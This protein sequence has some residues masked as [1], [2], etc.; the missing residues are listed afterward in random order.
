MG[1]VFVTGGSGVIGTALVNEPGGAR[2]RG[3]CELGLR[4]TD[5]RDTLLSTVEWAR[6]EG[7][8]KSAT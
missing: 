2:R 7:L 4:Y 3:G 1:R 6:S 5:P 8:L